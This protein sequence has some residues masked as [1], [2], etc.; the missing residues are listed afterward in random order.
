MQTGVDVERCLGVG[1]TTFSKVTGVAGTATSYLDTTVVGELVTACY[2][3]R[4]TGAA[5]ALS[6]YSNTACGISKMNDPTGLI[7]VVP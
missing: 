1:C 4:A 2:R 3:V 5:G 7:V 6:N